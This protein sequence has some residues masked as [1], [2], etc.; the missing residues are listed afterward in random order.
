M[1]WINVKDKEPGPLQFI[2][3]FRSPYPS[4]Y[5]MGF[6]AG[7]GCREEEEMFDWW[8]ELPEPPKE[9]E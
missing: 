5:W 7:I 4:Y 9:K 8:M 6:Y 1:E 3:A 2:L